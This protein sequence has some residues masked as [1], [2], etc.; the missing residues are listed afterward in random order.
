M[1]SKANGVV[2]KYQNS[3]ALGRTWAAELTLD[4]KIICA[5]GHKQMKAAMAEARYLAS[6]L[7]WKIAGWRKT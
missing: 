4:G 3:A 2:W 5:F 7:G 1:S 6:Q